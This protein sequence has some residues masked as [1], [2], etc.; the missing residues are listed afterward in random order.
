MKAYQALLPLAAV[1]LFAGCETRSDAELV[2]GQA[3]AAL[4]DVRDRAATTVPTELQAAE[5]T[6][7]RMKQDLAERDYKDVT[8][9]APQFN[10]QIATVKDAMVARETANAAA[11]HEWNALNTE[12]PQAVEAIQARVD[13]LRPNALPKDVTREELESAKAELESIK[14]TWAEATAAANAGNPLDATDKARIVQAKAE[15]L[16][17]T[18]GMNATLASAG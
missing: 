17:D 8:K 9:A 3:E 16:K 13:S 10:A 5:T 11:T 4:E 15:Q 14:A 6:L 1:I 12:V 18:L 2:V 7:A